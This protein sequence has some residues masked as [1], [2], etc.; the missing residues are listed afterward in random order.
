MKYGNENITD[1]KSIKMGVVDTSNSSI[2]IP[3]TQFDQIRSIL[4][5][6]DKSITVLRLRN[7]QLALTSRL[8]C[9]T[10]RPKLSELVFVFDEVTV[11]IQPDSFLEPISGHSGK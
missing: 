10:L 6:K 2:K 7:R 9:Q 8:N 5:K 4:M 11:T 1:F 3:N